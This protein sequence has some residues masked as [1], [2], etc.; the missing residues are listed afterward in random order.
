MLREDLHKTCNFCLQLF[1][2]ISLLK[3]YLHNLFF[4]Q[5]MLQLHVQDDLSHLNHTYDA[6]VTEMYDTRNIIAF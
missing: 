4:D 2:V 6:S 5:F 3:Q 1:H